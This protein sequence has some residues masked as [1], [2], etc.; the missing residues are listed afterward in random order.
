MATVK[1]DHVTVETQA[2][3]SHEGRCI[4]HTVLFEDG[5]KKML[6]VILPCDDKISE[7]QFQTEGSERVEIISGECEVTIKNHSESDY[8][9]TGQAFMVEGNSSFIIKNEQVVQYICHLEG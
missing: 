4:S 5:S 3:I 9:R 1:F 8:Y 7:Y 2:A 6:G